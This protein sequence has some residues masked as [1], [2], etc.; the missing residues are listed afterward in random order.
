M[1]DIKQDKSTEEEN[2]RK[3]DS[4]VSRM[5]QSQIQIEF[6]KRISI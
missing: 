6:S 5:Y 3:P 4:R 2:F 1:Q